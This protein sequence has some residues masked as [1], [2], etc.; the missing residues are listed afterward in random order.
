LLFTRPLSLGA[1]IKHLSAHGE[2]VDAISQ[3]LFIPETHTRLYDYN[4]RPYA[5]GFVKTQDRFFFTRLGD[6]RDKRNEHL[7][8]L[9]LTC[10]AEEL[11]K[12]LGRH[13]LPKNRPEPKY[14]WGGCAETFPFTMSLC[15]VCRFHFNKIS[16]LRL[17]TL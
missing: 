7:R 15:V 1:S 14:D 2:V 13:K 6:A 4:H 17:D 5:V 12:T 8:K 9:I 11:E 3:A 10:D 16:I